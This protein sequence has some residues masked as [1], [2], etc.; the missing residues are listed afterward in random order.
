MSTGATIAIVGGV[1]AVGVAAVIL[2]R[3]K[4]AAAPTVAAKAAT[5]T[6]SAGTLIANLGGSLVSRL[7]TD[8]I[9]SLSDKFSDWLS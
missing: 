8:A 6:P 4:T 7:G 3:P 9:D 1:V 5:G 2:L